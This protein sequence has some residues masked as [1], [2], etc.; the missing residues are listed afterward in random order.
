MER[1]ELGAFPVHQ[2]DLPPD[3]V[4]VKANEAGA[5]TLTFLSFPGSPDEA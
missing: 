4:M 2:L 3:V 5:R 1:D